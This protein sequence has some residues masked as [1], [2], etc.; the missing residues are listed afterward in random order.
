[1]EGDFILTAN[2]AFVGEGTDP[3]RKVG[4]MVR[5]S[6]EENAAQIAAT[7]HATD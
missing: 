1:M 6:E 7:L 5:A 2:F 4:W 3:H